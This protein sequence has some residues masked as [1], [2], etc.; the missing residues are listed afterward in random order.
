MVL[1]VHPVI[2]IMHVWKHNNNNW[3]FLRVSFWGDLLVSASV[4]PADKSSR[5]EPAETAK[6]EGR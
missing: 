5:D 6:R 4:I 1:K 3:L 2:V